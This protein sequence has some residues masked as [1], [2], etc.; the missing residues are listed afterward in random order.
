MSRSADEET[1]GLL[2]LDLALA[3]NESLEVGVG[4][5][6]SRRRSPVAEEARLDV[7]DRELL[8]H[9]AIALEEDLGSGEVAR[10]APVGDDRRKLWGRRISSCQAPGAKAELTCSTVA[11]SVWAR[12]IWMGME[13]RGR[14]GV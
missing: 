4:E 1:L 2:A 12:S 3:S 13:E 9:R 14:V 6:E 5:G 7:V 10:R 11:E 8:R